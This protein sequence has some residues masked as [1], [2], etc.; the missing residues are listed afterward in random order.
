MPAAV[1]SPVA[2]GPRAGAA[3]APGRR[4]AGIQG[5]RAFLLIWLGQLVSVTGSALTSF[6]L[7]VWVYGRTGSVTKY[8][9]LLL[10][11]ALPGILLSPVAGALIDRW[12]RRSALVAS[13]AGGAA[14]ALA[15]ALLFFAGRLELWHLYVLLAVASVC[16]AAQLPAFLASITVLVPKAQFGRAGGMVQVVQAAALVI[17]PAAGAA[18][19]AWTS[20][21]GVIL[22]DLATFLLSLA[23]LALVRVPAP[24]PAAGAAG[25]PSLLR[26]AALGWRFIRDRPGLVGLLCLLCTVNLNVAI[27]QALITPMILDFSTPKMLGAVLSVSCLGWLAGG[28]AM[29][30]WGGPRRRAAGVIGFGVTFGLGMVASGLRASTALIAASLFLSLFSVPCINASSQAIWQAKVAAAIQGRVFAVRQMIAWSTTPIGYLLAGPLADRVFK[31]LLRPGGRLVPML[32][33]LLGIGPGRGVGLLFV[34]MGCCSLLA[35]L[36]AYCFPPLRH[37]ESELPDQLP[38]VPAPVAGGAQ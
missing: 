6:A 21:A 3:A 37:V 16:R 8:S 13:D 25:R 26:E 30:A 27:V 18:L 38:A 32:G 23:T 19:L 5:S 31:P 33:R 28:I 7:G 1:S 22:I 20:V 2:G 10:A 24:A 36:A 35:C 11:A 14:V 34:T 4:R 9:L 12:G 17:G 29:S 15:L